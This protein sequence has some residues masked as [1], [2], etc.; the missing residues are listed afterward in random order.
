MLKGRIVGIAYHADF[1]K[2]L[3]LPKRFSKHDACKILNFLTFEHYLNF[4]MTKFSFQL[5][6]STSPCFALHKRYFSQHSF[7]MHYLGNVFLDKY[8][9]VE[10]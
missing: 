5:C 7:L 2:L 9:F 4:R 10:F 6:K 3:E 1:K 8:T